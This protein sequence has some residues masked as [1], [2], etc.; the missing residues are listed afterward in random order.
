[1]AGTLSGGEQQMLAIGSGLMSNPELIILDEPLLG[2]VPVMV[3]TI[4]RVIKDIKSL[5]KTILLVEQNAYKAL[6]TADRGYVLEQGSIVKSGRATDLINDPGVKE[7]YL[8][9]NVNNCG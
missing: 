4:F 5:G 3:E 9:V 2:L 1:M 6:A 8:G 7:S